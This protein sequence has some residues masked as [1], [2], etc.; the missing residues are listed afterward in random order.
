MV[1]SL[2]LEINLLVFLKEKEQIK[3]IMMIMIFVKIIFDYVYRC[4]I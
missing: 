1:I 3:Y 4:D 2:F